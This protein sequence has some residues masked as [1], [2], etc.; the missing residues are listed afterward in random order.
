[1]CSQS[2][3]PGSLQPFLPLTLSISLY[4]GFLSSGIERLSDPPSPAPEHLGLPRRLLYDPHVGPGGPLGFPGQQ[5]PGELAM[6]ENTPFSWLLPKLVLCRGVPHLLTW[7][8][9]GPLTASPLN[10]QL[11]VTTH[12][13]CTRGSRLPWHVLF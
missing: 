11:F 13:V 9:L 5:R 6:A 1:M 7:G 3:R 10:T 2:L 4:R 8:Q 12:V